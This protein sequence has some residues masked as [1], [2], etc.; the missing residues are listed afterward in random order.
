MKKWILTPAI[1]LAMT[2][3]AFA[4]G[5]K[6][7]PQ[8]IGFANLRMVLDSLPMKDS[9]V[10]QLKILNDYFSQDIAEMKKEYEA[11][12]MEYDA[13]IKS[14]SVDP[15]IREM[16]ENT[17]KTLEENIGNKTQKYQELIQRKQNELLQP[18]LDSIKAN[19]KIVAKQR[20][21]TQII[22][23][24]SDI[25]IYNGSNADDITN[26]VIAQMRAAARKSS[27]PKA[28]PR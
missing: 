12:L 20:A 14:A 9:A 23:I 25:L 4:Q 3:V 27:A 5:T 28:M 18:I 21:Y 2:T 24:S 10:A 16:Q 1:L 7:L 19:T 22:D 17:L 11:K 6:V 8:K 26:I 15:L 13:Y